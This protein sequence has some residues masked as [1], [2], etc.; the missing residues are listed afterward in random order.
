MGEGEGEEKVVSIMYYYIAAQCRNNPDHAIP[1]RE[2]KLIASGKWEIDLCVVVPFELRCRTCG[3]VQ[4][5]G[6]LPVKL[7][8][9]ESPIENLPELPEFQSPSPADFGLRS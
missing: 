4:Q 2:A 7:I 3:A 8:E 5:F 6:G 9:V 1:F